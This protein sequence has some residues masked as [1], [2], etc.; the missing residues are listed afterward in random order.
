RA[1]NEF[2][3]SAGI[4]IKPNECVA[5][6]AAMIRVFNEHGC[7]TDRKKARLK[8]LIDQWGIPKF[9]AALPKK[10]PSS[11]PFVPPEDGERPEQPVKHGHIGVF[12]QAQRGLNYIGVAI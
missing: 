12:K 11:L 5:V 7:R 4:L 2:A 10:L 9:L 1:H 6:A 8:D 3:K